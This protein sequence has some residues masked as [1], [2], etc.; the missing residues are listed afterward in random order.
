MPYN[1]RV[2]P[3]ICYGDRVKWAL[4][5]VQINVLLPN[6]T[7]YLIS[8]RICQ[9]IMLLV[10]DELNYFEKRIWNCHGRILLAH[11]EE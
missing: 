4:T 7:E 2:C 3:T 6:S 9:F 8:D 11:E 5:S 10:M 1:I